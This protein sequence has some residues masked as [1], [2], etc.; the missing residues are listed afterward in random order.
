MKITKETIDYVA[1]LS[2]LQLT[3]AESTKV[4]EDMEKIL[5]YMETMDKLDT[6]NVEP[7][8]H[9]FEITNV[10]RADEVTNGNE[11]EILLSNTKSKKD[12][13][14]MVPKTVD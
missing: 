8:S 12:G 13:C 9:V 3:E 6:S 10:F 5:S 11:R 1:A 4:M 2:K 7:M 14:F